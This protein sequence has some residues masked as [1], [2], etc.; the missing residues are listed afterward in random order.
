MECGTKV[1]HGV[2]ELEGID[3]ELYSFREKLTENNKKKGEAYGDGQFDALK[4]PHT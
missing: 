1:R 4:L 3:G 2:K